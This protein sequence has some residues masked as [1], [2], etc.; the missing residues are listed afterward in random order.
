MSLFFRGSNAALNEHL[1]PRRRRKRLRIIYR[2]SSGPLI[3]AEK[4]V[5]AVC[6]WYGRMGG[7]AVVRARGIYR[8]A[9]LHTR[10]RKSVRALC[11]EKES[12]SERERDL[13]REW[14]L[15]FVRYRRGED[16]Y[17]LILYV[18]AALPLAQL[19]IFIQGLA[20][21]HRAQVLT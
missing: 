19:I 10:E 2:Y 17:S 1:R 16:V 15:P 5:G 14:S 7:M 12:A 11:N 21:F 13:I 6:E 20:L 4:Y 18:G 9:C 8:C 3:Q